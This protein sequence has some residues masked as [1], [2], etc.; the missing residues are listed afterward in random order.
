MGKG[1]PQLDIVAYTKHQLNMQ[2]PQN[3][4][5]FNLMFRGGEA[6]ICSIVAHNVHENIGQC[7]Q[8]GTS[9]MLF[10]PLIKKLDMEQ[11][12]KDN[13]GLGRWTVMTLQGVGACTRI[14]V[15]YNP[16]RNNKPDSG[17]VYQQ[18]RRFFITQRKITLCPWKLFLQ[19]PCC[20]AAEM[21]GRQ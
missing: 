14:V 2:H 1:D 21:A 17:M 20:A 19:R 5:G 12:G 3:V 13:I 11:L 9:L 16:C 18:H 4:N 15:G 7:Q 8:R 10:G 6:E